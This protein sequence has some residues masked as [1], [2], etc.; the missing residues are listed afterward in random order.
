[1]P[2]KHNSIICKYDNSALYDLIRN[3]IAKSHPST[4]KQLLN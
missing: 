3:N 1:M 4:K 2:V